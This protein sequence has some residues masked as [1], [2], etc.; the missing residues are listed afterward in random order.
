VLTTSKLL[1]YKRK[2][3]GDWREHGIQE[4]HKG[5]GQNLTAGEITNDITQ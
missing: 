3:S 4:T 1:K 5:R 2:L